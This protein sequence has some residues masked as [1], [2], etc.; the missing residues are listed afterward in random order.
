MIILVTLILC[1]LFSHKLRH[2]GTKNGILCLCNIGE[3][4]Q[5]TQYKNVSLHIDRT[6][7]YF[8]QYQQKITEIDNKCCNVFAPEKLKLVFLRRVP[9][10]TKL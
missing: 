4:N 7:K 9:N 5:Q 6:N 8:G 2:N 1:V 3:Y 10:F